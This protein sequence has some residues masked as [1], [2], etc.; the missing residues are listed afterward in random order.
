MLPIFSSE[1][2]GVHSHLETGAQVSFIIKNVNGAAHAAIVREV[3]TGPT[4][5]IGP[6]E[7]R[8]DAV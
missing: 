6:P 2:D 4:P 3:H 5:Y 7:K 8:P 1:K